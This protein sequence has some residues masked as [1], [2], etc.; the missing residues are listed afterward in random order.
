M[1]D[2]DETSRSTQEMNKKKL[3]IIIITILTYFIKGIW[4][5]LQ[6]FRF[7]HLS[8]IQNLGN[9]FVGNFSLK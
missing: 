4:V 8:F 7:L 9:F 3:K 2:G 6:C 1:I 5:I